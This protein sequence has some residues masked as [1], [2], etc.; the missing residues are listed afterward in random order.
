MTRCRAAVLLVLLCVTS[1][2][3]H[4]QTFVVDERNDQS[5]G[6]ALAGF[7]AFTRPAEGTIDPIPRKRYYQSLFSVVQRQAATFPIGSASGGFTY[8]FDR[9]TG[10]PVRRSMSFGPMFAE[11][12]LTG[13]ARRLSVS[14][15]V[16][17][18]TWRGLAGTDFRPE[19][20]LTLTRLYPPAESGGD[21]AVG[22]TTLGMTF[23]TTRGVVAVAYGLTDRIDIGLVANSGSTSI[24]WTGIFEKVNVNTG[25]SIGGDVWRRKGYSAGIGDIAA[26]AKVEFLKRPSL[27]L[28][29]DVEVRFPTG[30]AFA[31]LGVGDMQTR[32]MLVGELPNGDISPH[33]N[34]GYTWVP[35]HVVEV[36]TDFDIVLDPS[37]AQLPALENPDEVNYTVGIDAALNRR[38]TIAGDVVGRSLLNSFN[39]EQS[40]STFLTEIKV[41]PGTVNLLL[42]A[43]GGKV[44]LGRNWLLNVFAVFPLTS[45]GLRPGITPV[46]GLERAM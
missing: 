7:L 16:Q 20:S 31:L 38:L 39:F 8:V 24:N 32:V 28:A 15:A 46:I 23:Y 44:L 22:T 13:G 26:R 19:H 6:D 25:R 2:P 34:F 5:P 36:A 12:P 41:T 9:T 35:G 10:V 27:D 29:A 14:F 40:I 30:D 11:R 3:T 1:R 21:A 4:A 18:T 45:A 43:V 42:G 37:F 33:F 17:N